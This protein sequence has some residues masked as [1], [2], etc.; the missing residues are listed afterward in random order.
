MST[1][2]TSD[3]VSPVA[4]N[5]A[6]ARDI[7]YH[8]HAYTNARKHEEIGPLVIDRGE[9]IHVFDHA[10][11]RYIEAMA[12][13]WSVAVGF[14]DK[15]LAA[16][17]AR[18]F[19]KLPY[20]HD[21]THKSH[22]PVIDL[23]EKLVS[24]A[25][26]PMSKAFFTNSGSEANDTVLKMIWYRSNALGQPERKKV[27]ARERAYHGVTI[28]SASLTGLP[29][30]HK[31]FDLPLA[32]ILR[33]GSPHFW[34]D[35][36]P[37]ETEEA[38]ATRR[39]DELEQLILAEGPET[40]AA[41]FAEPV[42]GAGGV[43]VPP[44]TYWDKIQA[45]LRKYDI[46]FVADEVI[47]GFGRTGRMFGTETFNLKPDVMVVS[48][49]LSS[50]YLPISAII[51]NERFVAPIMDQSNT[52]GTFGHGF[53]AGGHPVAAAVALENVRIIEEEGLV[54][55]AV[56]SG[57]RLLEGLHALAGHPLVG[58]VRGVGLIAAVELVTDKAAKKA[59]EPAGTLGGL[60]N[61]GLQANGVISRAMGDAIA[62]CPP[63]IITES[64]VDDLLS[65]F[66]LTLDTVAKQI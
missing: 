12:G 27:I 17:A 52:I 25:P 46:L 20:Y 56:A 16:A 19:E 65:R 50:S 14:G 13:L 42:M 53:T 8:L 59:L 10:G 43:I 48:K 61:A 38:F 60:V 66:A 45:V 6:E 2:S 3:T 24:M 64:E 23:A 11:N 63:L 39:A 35:A 41:F 4:P 1:T 28:A 30:N 55:N 9:G 37:G 44:A 62:F 32:G 54:A 47:C 49:A 18:Q 58:E 5:S 7:A 22:G 15:R 33:T 51:A 26:V 21:F 29:N 57:R 34:R 40:V 36:L 31:S